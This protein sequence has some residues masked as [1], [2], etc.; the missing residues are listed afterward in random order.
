MSLFQRSRLAPTPSL[1]ASAWAICLALSTIVSGCV[2]ASEEGGG[3]TSERDVQQEHD[4]RVDI[5]EAVELAPI[6]I[7]EVSSGG[8]DQIE[9]FNGTDE[10]V[11]LSGWI[12]QD[13]HLAATKQYVLPP[14][15]TL[16]SGRFLV[17]EKDQDH[18]FGLGGN[19][20]VT[21]SGPQGKLVDTT[22]W[23]KGAAQVSWCR[24]PNGTG[25]FTSCPF[26][27][28]GVKNPD[29]AVFDGTVVPPVWLS[30][31]PDGLEMEPDELGFDQTGRLW[32]GDP[33][34][35]R[36]LVFGADGQ[37]EAAITGF[38]PGDG[39]HA[40]RAAPNG[41]MYVCDRGRRQIGVYDPVTLNQVRS[42]EYEEFKDPKGIAFAA[43]GTFY[44][45]DQSTDEVYVFGADGT[46]QT[47]WPQLTETVIDK[48]G[49]VC[50]IPC[51]AETIAIDE[52]A[53]RAYVTS[54]NAG[55]IE[56]Y[57]LSTGTWLGMHISEPGTT[58]EPQAGR[59]RDEVEGVVVDVQRQLMFVV[60]EHNGR[61]MILDT[62]DEA[63][64]TDPA[65]D[66][67][68]LGAYGEVGKQP[69]QIRGADGL[70]IDST[71]T[72]LGLADQENERIQVHNIDTILKQLTITPRGPGG[73]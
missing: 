58:D 4:S 49:D 54:A 3:V 14:G 28:F 19:D 35:G 21:L 51:A 43:D 7:N 66:F 15:T 2:L 8:K 41:E 69:G 23:P 11:D 64:L 52:G 5:A 38:I 16:K 31:S 6:V 62:N 68:F 53:D 9:L 63:A 34:N 40:I 67:A 71:G 24:V 29:V 59:V 42:I 46:H 57:E 61:V 30:S 45:S 56:V 26:R 22:D 39:A 70:T 36:V 20:A 72:L 44:V 37:F 55:R 13:E 73:K 60:D 27:S 12:L 50:N 25:D 17:L 65:Q 33:P 47:T 32:A 10:T 1:A 18:T 48:D